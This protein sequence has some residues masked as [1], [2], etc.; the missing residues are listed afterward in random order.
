VEPATINAADS[1]LAAIQAAHLPEST[2]RAASRLIVEGKDGTER[3]LRARA[4]DIAARPAP[5][6]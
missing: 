4:R 2:R 3:A 6:W 5:A 1:A